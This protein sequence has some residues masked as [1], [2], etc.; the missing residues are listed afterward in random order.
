MRS[1]FGHCAVSTLD[2]TIWHGR[3]LRA[4]GS[5]QHF[6]VF[7]HDSRG[8]R[9]PITFLKHISRIIESKSQLVILVEQGIFPWAFSVQVIFVPVVP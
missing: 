7:N 2:S 8:S 1:M 5:I 6:G 3:G 4:S 9:L